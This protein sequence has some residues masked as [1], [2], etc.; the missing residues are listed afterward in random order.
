[1]S[2]AALILA[3]GESTRMGRLKLLL[4][5]DG[6]PLIAWQVEQVRQAGADEIVVVLGHAAEEVRAVVPAGVRIVV[7]D[8]YKDGRATSLRRGAEGL[9]DSI[10]AILILNVDQPRPAWVTRLVLKRWR[11]THAPIVLPRF[12]G[13]SGH[14]VLIDGAL[15]PELRAVDEATFGLRAVMQRHAAE[16]IEIEIDND[17]PNVDLNTPS[18]YEAALASY[19]AGS[20]QE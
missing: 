16:G 2:V 11:E 17:A 14:P 7:N 12:A 20:W 4:P 13:H 19:Q 5:W 3:A 1:M 9:D 15:L 6:S 10:E 8:A 18:D